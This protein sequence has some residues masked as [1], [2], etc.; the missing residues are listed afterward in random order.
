[1]GP[2]LR[3]R[4]GSQKERVTG[5]IKHK[6]IVSKESSA[7]SFRTSLVVYLKFRFFSARVVFLEGTP[8]MRKLRMY[9]V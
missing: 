9:F 1:M 7:V 6:T 3:E 5:Q 2:S 8:R 4:D